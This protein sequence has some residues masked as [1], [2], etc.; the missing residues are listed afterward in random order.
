MMENPTLW[1]ALGF[2]VFVALA[3]KPAKKTV[4]GALDRRAEQ[5]EAQLLEAACLRKEA[6]VLLAENQKRQQQAIADAAR[7]VETAK[8]QAEAL[9]S[10]AEAEIEAMAARRQQ[11]ALEK[12]TQAEAVA[13]AQVRGLAVETAVAVTSMLLSE[14]VRGDVAARL[15]DEAIADLPSRLN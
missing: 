8:A 11:A 7:I 13:L 4:L 14:K 10:Q 9:K 3:F 15:L 12:I 5:I 1:V 2:I 6:E